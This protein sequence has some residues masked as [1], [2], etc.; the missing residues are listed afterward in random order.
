MGLTENE[1]LE[2]I[3]IYKINR[4]NKKEEINK[5]IDQLSSDTKFE[6]NEML[7]KINSVMYELI[8]EYKYLRNMIPTGCPNNWQNTSEEQCSIPEP[9]DLDILHKKN[10]SLSDKRDKK[11]IISNDNSTQ[12][13]KNK[14]KPYL[15]NCKDVRNLSYQCITKND[16]FY[17]KGNQFDLCEKLGGTMIKSGK[18]RV[19]P[20]ELGASSVNKPTLEECMEFAN[21]TPGFKWRT[22]N[23]VS[24]SVDKPIGCYY[25]EGNLDNKGLNRWVMYNNN[26]YER[27]YYKPTSNPKS[28]EK[29]NWQLVKPIIAPFGEL[30]QGYHDESKRK[31]SGRWG[32]DRVGWRHSSST[33]NSWLGWA[34]PNNRKGNWMM[35]DMGANK[36]IGGFIIQGRAMSKWDSQYVKK[37]NI[38]LK[39]DDGSFIKSISENDEYYMKDINALSGNNQTKNIIFNKPERARYI[40]FYPTEWNDHITMRADVLLLKY[41][42][43]L[44]NFI[45]G[46]NS[47]MYRSYSSTYNNNKVKS[48]I[49][50]L[51]CWT[52]KSNNLNEWMVIDM[53]MEKNIVGVVVQG[54]DNSD[55]YVKKLDVL[56]SND[57]TNWE[58]ALIGIGACDRP[59]QT[60][61]IFFDSVVKTR[62]V[63]FVPKSWNK[64]ICL[65]ADIL[66]AK[67]DYSNR[68]TGDINKITMGHKKMIDDTYK[69]VKEI[70]DNTGNDRIKSLNVN[71][72]KNIYLGKEKI[73]KTLKE[74]TEQIID[75]DIFKRRVGIITNNN[76][77]VLY[78]LIGF[79]ILAIV[80]LIMLFKI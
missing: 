48:M 20:N 4:D 16:R 66:E 15:T 5:L 18:L 10:N 55:E 43:N 56:I 34:A 57:N 65:R 40:Y 51:K 2:K 54:D 21:M 61:V 68:V 74:I 9:S 36:D 79:V 30:L 64:N 59:N 63:K 52:P 53:N 35:I 72:F 42:K 19:V 50:S 80:I 46:I 22:K 24:N 73:D 28:G 31:Y 26:N 37:L 1:L 14:N 17:M 47:E 33:L 32:N 8:D 38:K 49:N 62:Y 70:I 60:K 12:C 29:K 77:R 45:L 58:N 76:F 44:H 75:K 78:K 71:K 39:K 69:R 67:Y 25:H 23:A 7:E 27:T 6:G 3:S 11:P 13:F 41:S